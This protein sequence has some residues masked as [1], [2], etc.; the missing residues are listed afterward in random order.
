MY[1]LGN[2]E[3][4]YQK[5]DFSQKSSLKC[6][7]STSNAIHTAGRMKPICNTGGDVMSLS[8]SMFTKKPQLGKDHEDSEQLGGTNFS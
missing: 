6:L 2:R 3:L 5:T 7:I 4:Q 1:Q 8:V